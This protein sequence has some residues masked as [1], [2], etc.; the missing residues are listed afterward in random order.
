VVIAV[1]GGMLL[2]P[3]YFQAVRG[4]SAMDTGLLLAPQGF[5]AMVAMPIAGRLTDR[6][7]IGRIVPVGLAI[8][9]LSFLALTQLAADTSYLVLGFVL[10]L[11]A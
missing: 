5:G 9:A 8:V 3:L 1:F 4:E 7:G 10:F 2:L 6:T 11:W